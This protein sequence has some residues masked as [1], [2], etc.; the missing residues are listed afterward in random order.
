MSGMVLTLFW[1]LK[2]QTSGC[3]CRQKN[4]KNFDCWMITQS[5]F[6][7]EQIRSTLFIWVLRK[8]DFQYL[9]MKLEKN[10]QMFH[11]IMRTSLWKELLQQTLMPHWAGV[12]RWF[13][14]IIAH[15]SLYYH[16]M[17]CDSNIIFLLWIKTLKSC[18][19]YSK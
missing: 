18:K 17:L 4:Q 9:E 7:D 2:W 19:K 11:P 15:T 12:L 14:C 10:I 3:H 1:F 16:Y 8:G 13:I 5:R 6:K